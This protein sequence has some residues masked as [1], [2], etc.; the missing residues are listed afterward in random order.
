METADMNLTSQ[1]YPLWLAQVTDDDIQ[2]GRI[3][4][5]VAPEVGSSGHDPDAV[6]QPIVVFDDDGYVWGTMRASRTAPRFIGDDRDATI[7]S[8]RTWATRY[9]RGAATG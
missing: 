7:E 2:S 6:L 1:P 4:A 9:R 5:W 8:A 3:V